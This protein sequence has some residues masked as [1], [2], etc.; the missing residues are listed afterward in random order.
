M[1]CSN[2][3]PQ[4]KGSHHWRLQRITSVL[5]IPLTLWFV[6]A[7]ISL[8]SASYVEALSW[9]Q[10]PLHALILAGFI[11]LCCW[12]MFM[13]LE[14]VIED[15]ISNQGIAKTAILAIRLGAALLALVGI[16]SIILIATQ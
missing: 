4:V 2:Q 10:Q 13:G 15:Y 8:S 1:S 7:I 6:S 3:T 11:W 14:V 5:L 12:H 9:V 16:I